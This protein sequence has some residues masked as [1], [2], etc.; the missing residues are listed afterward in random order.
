MIFTVSCHPTIDKFCF[1][2]FSLQ[3]IFFGGEFKFQSIRGCIYNWH[4]NLI[5]GIGVISAAVLGYFYTKIKCMAAFK[6]PTWVSVPLLTVSI[7][8]VWL[9]STVT[10][11]C[12]CVFFVWNGGLKGNHSDSSIWV[13]H[14]SLIMPHGGRGTPLYCRNVT[15]PPSFEWCRS[16]SSK[17]ERVRVCVFLLV[18]IVMWAEVRR[19]V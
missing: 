7:L 9:W 4:Q 2:S 14:S 6:L 18:R 5:W 15:K 13:Q 3:F 11:Q 1:Y 12:V 10:A 17:Y 16:R 19:G 8:Y